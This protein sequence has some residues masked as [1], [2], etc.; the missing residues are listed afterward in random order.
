[1][2]TCHREEETI[3]NKQNIRSKKYNNKDFKKCI[4]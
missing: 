3:K 2:R 1:M 4:R